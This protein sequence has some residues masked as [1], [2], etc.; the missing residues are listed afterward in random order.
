MSQQTPNSSWGHRPSKKNLETTVPAAVATLD[1][2]VNGGKE[3]TARLNVEI[4][5]ALRARV[6]ARCAM[7][8][9][10]IKDVVRELLQQRF[11]A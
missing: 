11:P 3:E 7:E 4:P 10:E 2:F 8:G 1:K 9:R 6:K 5:K